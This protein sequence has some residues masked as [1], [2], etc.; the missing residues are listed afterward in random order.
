MSNSED[1][2]AHSSPGKAG[3]GKPSGTR[4]PFPPR[5]TAEVGNEKPKFKVTRSP[6]AH[7]PAHKVP[8]PH[9]P[10]ASP[11]DA[12]A[13]TGES[14]PVGVGNFYKQNVSAPK[15]AE[16][17]KILAEQDTSKSRKPSFIS[18]PAT[19]TPHKVEHTGSYEGGVLGLSIDIVFA[20]VAIAAAVLIINNLLN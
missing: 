2:S 1:Q 7:R 4:P 6:F 3:N 11:S 14:N 8:A 19:P 15:E 18:K 20:V 12:P 16:H 17:T 5:T 10:S 9:P 13:K